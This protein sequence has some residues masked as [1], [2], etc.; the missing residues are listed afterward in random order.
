MLGIHGEEA[1]RTR[2]A[3]AGRKWS[4]TQPWMILLVGLAACAPQGANLRDTTRPASQE[5]TAE[6]REH[7][8]D[9][10]VVVLCGRTLCSVVPEGPS[11]RAETLTQGVALVEPPVAE[12]E[13]PERVGGDV[14]ARPPERTPVITFEIHPDPP[15]WKLPPGIRALLAE[16]AKRPHVKHHIFPQE[17][18]P[19]FKRK[20]INI[21]NWV[22]VLP[23]EDHLRIHRGQRGG[24]WNA[25]WR[26]WILANRISSK[27]ED[28]YRFAGEMIYRYCLTGT[29]TQYYC[30]NSIPKLV[31]TTHIP[32]VSEDD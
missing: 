9:R 15:D 18:K 5:V 3:L 31:P 11:P 12:L 24:P 8:A 10:E 14:D 22:M 2:P 20:G 29:L 26:E 32:D 30:I 19:F 17:F 28:I 6:G 1:P 21:H 7:H 4:A 16:Q 23:L 25:D 27:Q 13:A